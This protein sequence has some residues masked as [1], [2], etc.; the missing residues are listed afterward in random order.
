MR[1]ILRAIAWLAIVGVLSVGLWFADRLGQ[2]PHEEPQYA[3]L[4]RTKT[5]AVELAGTSQRLIGLSLAT[6]ERRN[7]RRTIRASCQVQLDSNHATLVK[8]FVSGMIE[9]RLCEQGDVVKTGQPLFVM[10]SN[11]LALAKGAYLSA[12]AQ[13]DLARVVLDRDDVL[14]KD[15]IVSQTQYDTDR[16]GWLTARTGFVNAREQLLIDGLAEA[17]IE[18][19]TYENQAT[20]VEAVVTSPID[21]VVVQLTNAHTRGDLVPAQTDLCQVADL[22]RVWVIGNAYEKDI[23]SLHTGAVARLSFVS[24]PG[25]AWKGTVE[26]ISEVVNP[27]TRTVDV[28]IAVA[29]E[30]PAGLGVR[31]PL[32]PGLFGTIEIE[33]DAY[34]EGWIW[35]PAAAILPYFY[36]GGEKGVFVATDSEHFVERRVRVAS[37]EGNDA[38]VVGDLAPG[39][40]VVT[41]GNIFLTRHEEH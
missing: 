15:K 24:Y 26:T 29:N 16:A 41:Q 25:L 7:A 4:E 1:P 2:R 28:R 21:G 23:A 35:I 39:E 14:I 3:T 18:K 30:A 20:W 10:R 11:D 37:Q 8:S 19:V 17:D 40:H 38:A 36:E 9:R 32:K 34:P 27:A 6:A 12:K 13:L 22:S 5:E 33:C 31:Y